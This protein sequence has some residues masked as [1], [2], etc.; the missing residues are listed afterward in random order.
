MEDIAI[1]NFYELDK[2][3]LKDIPDILEA[4]VI[5][6]CGIEL[7]EL[8]LPFKIP[9]FQLQ[10]YKQKKY[11][12]IPSLYIIKDDPAFKRQLWESLKVLFSMQ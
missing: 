6:I 1:V 4:Q 2:Q 9:L 8:E 11:V 3:K 5:I 10:H 7:S 12:S